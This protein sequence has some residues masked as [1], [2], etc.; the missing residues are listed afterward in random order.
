MICSPDKVKS[1]CVSSS[2]CQHRGM[3]VNNPI[4]HFAFFLN[5]L[6]TCFAHS[7]PPNCAF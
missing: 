7:M 4:T 1:N 5:L 6:K 2:I 3:L